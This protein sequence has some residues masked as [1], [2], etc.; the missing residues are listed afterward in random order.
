MLSALV[1]LIKHAFKYLVGYFEMQNP[2]YKIM[3]LA[4]K[5]LIS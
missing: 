5:I 3:F 4:V 1:V 2:V